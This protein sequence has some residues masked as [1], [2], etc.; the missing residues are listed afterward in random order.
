[1]SN[2]NACT[3]CGSKEISLVDGFFYCDI[4]GE[5]IQVGFYTSLQLSY[6]RSSLFCGHLM[7]KFFK[8]KYWNLDPPRDRSR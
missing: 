7:L 6:L 3:S 4:C 1:M 2:V 8:V 5:Q